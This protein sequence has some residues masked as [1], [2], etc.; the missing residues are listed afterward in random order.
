MEP[1][2]LHIIALTDDPTIRQTLDAL[3]PDRFRVD[4]GEEPAGALAVLTHTTALLVVDEAADVGY[5]ALIRRCRRTSVALDAFVIGGPKSDEVRRAEREEGVDVYFERPVE[6]A[7]LT[8]ALRHRLAHV[9]LKVECGIIGRSAGIE[10]MVESVLQVG[11]TEVAILIEGESGTG[12]DILARAIHTASRRADKTFEAVSVGAL[13]EGVLESELFGH[14]KGAF[15]G[16]IARRAGLFER[17][18]GGT[19][20]LDEIGETSANMQVRLLRVL[21][22]GEVMRVGGVQGL[23]VDIRVI[24]ATNR[25][26]AEAVRDGA[27]R[28]D[29]YYRL[30]GISMR[31]P[32]LRER[33]GDIAMLTQH[34][35]LQGNRRHRKSVRGIEPAALRAL[36]RYPWPGNIRELRNVVDTLVV[37]TVGTRITAERVEAQLASDAAAEEPRP[38][39]LLPV[40][41]GRPREE[42]EREMLYGSILALHR[43]VREILSLLQGGAPSVVGGLREVRPEPAEVDEVADLSLSQLERATVQEALTRHRGNRRRAAEALGISERTLYRKIKEYG[44]L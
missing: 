14:E 42:A 26:L 8:A 11:P 41:L 32:P 22:T 13:A 21:E 4:F 35:I 1:K 7:V 29:L 5:T 44:L 15:T 38:S 24:A 6:P 17:A 9:A 37:L 39:A 27:F 43:D 12:K 2:Q 31:V 33:R 25:R 40:P 34:F 16:A 36:E 10:E 18:D 23:R 19:V 30:K 28:Q 3:D 20:F